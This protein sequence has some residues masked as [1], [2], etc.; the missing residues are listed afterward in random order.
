[1]L[2]FGNALAQVSAWNVG[3]FARVHLGRRSATQIK[4]IVDPGR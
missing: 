1:M 3:G 2:F 4:Q